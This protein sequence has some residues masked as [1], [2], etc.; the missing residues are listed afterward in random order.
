[1]QVVRSLTPLLGQHRVDSMVADAAA[2]L[3]P[4]SISGGSDCSSFRDKG[5]TN[6]KSCGL[7]YSNDQ[8]GWGRP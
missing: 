5:N 1:M 2:S 4:A 3:S 6:G 7:D 8:E